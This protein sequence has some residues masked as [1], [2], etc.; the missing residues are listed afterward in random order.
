MSTATTIHLGAFTQKS[1]QAAGF[2]VVYYEAGQGAP[3][4]V[5]P[6]AG[7]PNLG[8]PFAQR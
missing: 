1:I 3:I 7:G 6:G 4:V 2:D 8:P 5:L